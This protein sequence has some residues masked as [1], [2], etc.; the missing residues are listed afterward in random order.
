MPLGTA[1]DAVPESLLG[2]QNLDARRGCED[3]AEIMHPVMRV[4]GG[5]DAA[6]AKLVELTEVF[7]FDFELQ[8]R[9]SALAAGEWHQDPGA[10]PAALGGIEFAPNAN[11]VEGLL[12]IGGQQIIRERAMPSRR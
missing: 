11:E 5:S 2:A 9:T 7:Q 8:S 4:I 1:V 6:I 10:E 3:L 12:P